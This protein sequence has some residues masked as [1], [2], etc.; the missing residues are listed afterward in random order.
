MVVPLIHL[1]HSEVSFPQASPRIGAALH[2]RQRRPDIP[3]TSYALLGRL[4]RV[5]WC[6]R[7]APVAWRVR[8]VPLGIRCRRP[9]TADFIH[10]TL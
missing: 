7:L 9:P 6:L 4:T 1:R 5:R 3:E 8:G 2:P 10:W